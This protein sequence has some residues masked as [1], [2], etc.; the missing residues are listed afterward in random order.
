[1]IRHIPHGGTIIPKE[2]SHFLSEPIPLRDEGAIE[3]F[4][5][6]K[7]LLFPVDRLIC[8]VERFLEGEPMEEKGMGVCY[9]KNAAGAP[10][11]DVS[12]AERQEIIRRYYEPHHARLLAMVE[13]ELA[14]Y[15]R[16]L[17]IDGHT[18]SK[19]P[20]PFETDLLRPE[21]DI[22]YDD[23]GEIGQWLV[24]RLSSHFEVAVN[25]PFAGALKPLKYLHD[26]RVDSVMIEVRRDVAIEKAQRIIGEALEELER[27]Y[28]NNS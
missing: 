5:A 22:G 24:K 9:T 15:G 11:R 16:C 17:I 1:M 3:I 6:G 28:Y 20:M 25:H 14:L 23:S 8:D 13:E 21:I 19:E 10:L 27:I 4:G 12:E 18:Y 2:Y 7:C 26:E